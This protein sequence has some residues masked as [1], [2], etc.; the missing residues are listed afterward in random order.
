MCQILFIDIIKL[1]NYD[2]L[3]KYLEE[4]MGS[5]KKMFTTRLDKETIKRLKVLSANQDKPVNALLEEAIQDL[6]KKHKGK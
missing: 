5:E 2:L 6:I 4:K 1:L 3:Q